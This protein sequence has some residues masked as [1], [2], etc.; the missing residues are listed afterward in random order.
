MAETPDTDCSCI[1]D[2]SGLHELATA[3]GNL[4][5][6]LIASLKDGTIGVP[7]WAWQEFKNLYGEEATELAEH[8]VKRIQFSQHVHVRAA[9]IT[10]QLN[11]AFSRGAYDDHVGRYTAAIALNKGYT[12]VT[13]SDNVTAYNGRECPA[14][15]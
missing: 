9:Q 11:L 14:L 6:T 7:S 13:S 15:C 10:E 5:A 2:T 1:I 12:V 8:V 4:K 3:S